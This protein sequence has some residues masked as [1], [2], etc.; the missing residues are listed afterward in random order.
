M[1]EA[2]PLHHNI[3]RG[4]H[5]P[6]NISYLSRL[7]TIVPTIKPL[8]CHLVSLMLE[9]WKLTFQINDKKRFKCPIPRQI[10]EFR[11]DILL[12]TNHAGRNEIVLSI[13]KHF[14]QWWHIWG[15]TKHSY[16]ILLL[17]LNEHLCIC[18]WT[19]THFDFI[20]QIRNRFFFFF[21]FFTFSFISYYKYTFFL[22]NLQVLKKKKKNC[23][24]ILFSWYKHQLQT[25][26]YCLG[27]KTLDDFSNV[28]L[29]F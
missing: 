23:R 4:Q 12:I 22:P 24:I 19:H 15:L 14:C 13:M 3:G 29:F 2:F 18:L 17:C 11:L 25:C 1:A 16:T 28:L 7:S 26:I 6:C 10:W 27:L 9:Y 21:F 8:V 20:F 5:Y